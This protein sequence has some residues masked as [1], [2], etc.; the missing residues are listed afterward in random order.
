MNEHDRTASVFAAAVA[1]AAADRAANL[2]RTC[3]GDLA[4][5]QRVEA[6]L[7]AHDQAAHF[8]DRPDTPPPGTVEHV[9][10]GVV[11]TLVAG[12]YKLLETIGEGGMGTVWMAEQREPVKRLVAL[13]L[14]KAGMDSQAVLARFEA[15]RQAL[16]LMD[17][18]HIAKVL[19]GGTTDNGH[20]Y[21]VMELVKG[22]PLTEYCD[23]RRLSVQDRLQLFVH[24][25]AAVQHAHQKGIIHRDLKPSN[26]LVTEHDGKP[27]PKVIDFGLAKALGAATVLTERTLHTAYGTVVGTPLYMAPEQVGINALDVDTRTDIYALGAILY[28]LLTGTTPLEKRRF[29]E[30]AWDE[31]RR[32]IREE[33]PARPSLRLSSSDALPTLAAR[34]QTE[35]A[36]LSRLIKGDLDWIALKAL[37]KD[38]NRRYE[39]ANGLALDVQRHLAGEPVLAAPPS[40]RYRLRKF[41]RKRRGPLL[42]AALV[43]LAL[44]AGMAGT[45][46]GLVE[47]T[48]QRDAADDART[49]EATQRQVA[50]ASA[51]K[52]A[53]A[54]QEEARQR[55]IAEAHAKKAAQAADEE[56][57][58]RDREAEQ[59]KAAVVAQQRAM[60]A[61]RAT[62]DDIMEQLLGARPAL[63]PTEKAFLQAALKRWQLF[64]AEKGASPLARTIRAEGLFRVAVLRHKL[65]E[66]EAAQADYGQ[67]IGLQEQL[68]AE[69]PAVPAYRKDLARS[70]YNLGVLLK[71]LGKDAQAEEQ[72]RQALSWQAQLVAEFPTVA[73]YRHALALSHNSLGNLLYGLDKRG[74]AEAQ[75]HQALGLLEQLV[76]EF[77]AVPAYRYE[78]AASHNSLG[79]LLQSLGKRV[80][81]EA[82]F[83]KALG[84][85][86]VLAAEFPAVPDYRQDLAISHNNLGALLKDLGKPAEAE[87]QLRQALDLRKKLVAEFPAV[88]KYRQELANSHY[89]LSH[90]F[91]DLGKRVEAEAQYR[92]ALALQ[93]KL[94]AE[95]PAVPAYRHELARSHHN[96]GHVL[97]DLGKW[98]EAEEQYRRA[99]ALYEKLA[100][101]FP[102]VPKYRQELAN[103]HYNLGHVFQDLGKRAEAEEQYR[104]ALDLQERLAAEF[105]DVAV[106]R[107]ELARSRNNLG[108]VLAGVG[109]RVEA[110]A[111]FRQ[112]LS[113]YEKL[114]A[115][116]PAVSTYR[117][118]LAGA[119][120]NLGILLHG[121][122][123]REEAEVQFRKA[124]G[125]R[126]V[127]AAE[128]PAVAGY[129]ID[130]GGSL[131]NIG[132][133]YQAAGKV[134]D[135]LDWYA[136]AI[137]TLGAVVKQEPGQ[138]AARQLL[139]NAHWSQAYALDRLGRHV[140]AVTDWDQAVALTPA[141][142]QASLKA[143]RA[144]SQVKAG[145]VAAAIAEVAELTT[146]G[147]WTAA[148]WYNFACVYALA[149][150]RDKDKQDEHARRA[151]ELL[152]RA[153][154]AGYKDV[155][156]M[157]KDADLDP[158]RGR[159]D[160]QKIIEAVSKAKN[161]APY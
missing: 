49:E 39:T 134:A 129:Q 41:L 87:E 11:G 105:P 132:N 53:A 67:A 119:H 27:V 111:Q 5:R 22:L 73:A 85:R 61:L 8:L 141:A 46:W 29:K 80:E 68:A 83:R 102:A 138:G 74:E 52:A 159:D 42:A 31:V 145:Q 116:Y 148:R 78:L 6:L 50:E 2:D 115:E 90:V 142:Q 149:S 23:D 124:L 97:E 108:L 72:C 152:Q 146:S 112:A 3:A 130:L 28:E 147:K 103:S 99:L 128:F 155:D 110:E 21:F 4:L 59:R 48:Q 151:V 25:C 161:P 36:K 15:E 160:F 118:D 135:S 104:Q 143:D 60:E 26:I 9:P 88:P 12:R 47:A 34:R 131:L 125:L 35:P 117:Q 14:I 16:A 158:L 32:L 66:W 86:Q 40:V 44:L 98:A 20:P 84:L 123:K 140:E 1:L 157:K 58:A 17:H 133:L 101:E 75:Y 153:V 96:L 136:R 92:Q 100:G 122:G 18:P 91:Q 107:L 114:A 54:L 121:L 81:A 82:R 56:R 71:T 24:I 156:H 113:L 43:L 79:V 89:N 69:F 120:N 7:R 137:L 65:G 70:H 154:Q 57:Q 76:A 62:T 127:L 106:Y 10:D 63:G 144:L 45:T 77:P 95:Y 19:D 139:R 33:E 51:R 38:R 13:K 37:E 30:A 126:Q 150:A 64:A 55:H 94:A 93:Q 109:K